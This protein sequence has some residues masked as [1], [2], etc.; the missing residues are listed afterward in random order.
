MPVDT[1][2]S[3]D[4]AIHLINIAIT[5]MVST[6]DLT[7]RWKEVIEISD[8]TA[9]GDIN[10]G[11][12]DSVTQ[13]SKVRAAF[14]DQ[15]KASEDA[16]ASLMAQL[17]ADSEINL[18]NAHKRDLQVDES[19][20]TVTRLL[21]GNKNEVM[22]NIRNECDQNNDAD[23]TY[24]VKNAHAGGDVKINFAQ[25]ILQDAS[26]KCTIKAVVETDQK[27]DGGITDDQSD[28]SKLT[29][30]NS[31]AISFS[32]VLGIIIAIL[33]V[34]MVAGDIR[35]A[36][37]LLAG[38]IAVAGSVCT[39]AGVFLTF[40]FGSFGVPMSELSDQYDSSD[41]SDQSKW[42]QSSL[43]PFRRNW[44]IDDKS[45]SVSGYPTLSGYKTYTP[46][47]GK[48]N[49]P[50]LQN[51]VSNVYVDKIS[52]TF[53]AA[54]DADQAVVGCVWH[55]D[56]PYETLIGETVPNLD[57]KVSLTGGADTQKSFWP[58]DDNMTGSEK[59]VT[60]DGTEYGY[61]G[62]FECLQLSDPTVLRSDGEKK[63]SKTKGIKGRLFLYTLADDYSSADLEQ[64]ASNYLNCMSDQDMKE[65][66]GVSE[67]WPAGI[68]S[69]TG[70]K[71]T[72]M[73]DATT[74]DSTVTVFSQKA[75]PISKDASGLVGEVCE[76]SCMVVGAL[77]TGDYT[78]MAISDRL[79]PDGK[80]S[81]LDS[82]LDFDTKLNME[83]VMIPFVSY[84]NYPS[85]VEKGKSLPWD[86][87]N[88]RK[89]FYGSKFADVNKALE[90]FWANVALDDDDTDKGGKG[91][92]SK[93][94]FGDSGDDPQP[95]KIRQPIKENV[96]A[97][98]GSWPVED[99]GTNKGMWNS[100]KRT[101]AGYTC[102]E[103]LF[104]AWAIANRVLAMENSIDGKV[105]NPTDVANS[106][107]QFMVMPLDN[108]LYD[109][110]PCTDK[111]ERCRID[112]L[113]MQMFIQCCIII[114]VHLVF[115]IMGPTMVTSGMLEGVWFADALIFITGPIALGGVVALTIYEG[116]WTR[117]VKAFERQAVDKAKGNCVPC[118]DKK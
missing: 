35:E 108:A 25:N 54:H 70:K 64:K 95:I 60:V 84:K 31:P 93:L 78:P 11:N 62:L 40:G 10:I 114:L 99:A 13:S 76:Q 22:N 29:V 66:P 57:S 100:F 8:I 18:H 80:P 111:L 9:G 34:L 97:P 88:S 59:V 26:L 20:H 38:L 56:A 55:R 41:T 5:N 58:A 83:K 27:N 23:S 17:T 65:F 51:P 74:G 37:I 4:D 109:G 1:S 72:M 112:S 113:M 44:F 110:K 19:T 52:E 103:S 91:G 92:G 117:G 69:A 28:T 63:D 45:I 115:A 47:D 33:L 67:G 49:D 86:S 118:N 36:R 102:A 85:V 21:V 46:P 42:V 73:Y 53:K 39:A 14:S 82:L 48:K 16:N 43:I 116:I 104:P 7:S 71:S 77:A 105:G 6:A 3:A 30:S 90:G 87:D 81:N 32:S 89:S 61:T 96:P 2:A 106:V 107:M 15:V 75:F 50:N 79:V 98:G 101:E 68:V 94:L 24:I 12:C